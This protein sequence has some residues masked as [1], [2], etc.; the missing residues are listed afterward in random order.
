MSENDFASLSCR[1]CGIRF[2]FS[3]L[4]EEM[5]MV[6][7]HPDRVATS[8]KTNWPKLSEEAKQDVLNAAK[9]EGCI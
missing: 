8:L 1:G 7:G 4:I 5:W 3:K 9:K 2:G 6:S